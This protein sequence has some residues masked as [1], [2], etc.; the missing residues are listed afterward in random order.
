MFTEGI[1]MKNR[2][3]QNKIRFNSKCLSAGLGISALIAIFSP[4]S[5]AACS[6]S[7]DSEWPNGFTA[8]ITIKNDT[9]APINNWN[10]NWQYANNR[11]SG[12][13]NANFSGSNPYSA[14]NMSWNGTIAVGQ[15]VSFG[16][17]GEKA[18]GSAERPTI[19]GALCGGTTTPASS[20]RSSSSV[21][22]V[23]SSKMSSSSIVASSSRISS[24]SS[25]PSSSVA[26]S[27]AT[28]ACASQIENAFQMLVP[29]I[30]ASIQAEDFDPAGYSD[31]STANE[32]G[33]YRTDTGVDIKSIANGNAVGWMRAGEWL[34]YTVYVETEG[35]YD[36]T[37]RSGAVGAGRTFNISQCN[38]TLVES[39]NVPN[40]NNWGEFKTYAAGKIHLKPGYQKIRVTVGATDY[41]DLDWIHIGP[42]SGVIDS[43]NT[44]TNPTGAVPSAGCGTARSLQNGR[45]NLNVN[46]LN[47]SYIL[48]VPDN[49]NNQNPYRL[50]VG[51]HWLNGDATQVANGGNGSATETPYYGLWN[52][53]QNSTIFIA[54]E[55][56]DKGWANSGGRDLALTDSIL[57]QVQSNLCIDKSR[58]FATGFSYG[59]GMSNAVACARANVF[60]GV[61]LYS[62]AQLS[63]C[64]GGTAPIPFFAAHGL[65]DDVL[66]ISLGRSL[67]DRAVRNNKCTAQ[68]PLEPARGSGTHI[69]TS[70]QGCTTGYPVRWCAFDG[71]HWPSQH[72][73]G[74]AESWIPQ[75]AWKFISQF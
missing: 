6:Y 27:A 56:I 68:N 70:Y 40:V 53:A 73:A 39:F 41:A 31:T 11:M 34:E 74:Q 16:V 26:S 1:I 36:L 72:D 22:V 54:P 63:G 75:E 29:R 59:A 24:S 4:S 9:G 21:A 33:A 52:L 48:R 58:I 7:I 66:G 5:M 17:Q 14:T 71:G 8:S 67:R 46:G 50:I 51:Y 23:S 30:P 13:W 32:G 37:I 64:D 49:Y 60:R 28:N 18:N 2:Q 42:Y 20:S 10:V 3:S 62:G 35:D 45:I 61:A 57:N 38:T 44:P 43:P 19:N 12:G 55:G 69:C 47:R 65:G 15:S 25:R